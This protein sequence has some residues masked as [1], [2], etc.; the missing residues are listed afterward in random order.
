MN[1]YAIRD[2]LIGHFMPPF[3]APNDY[4]AKAAIAQVVNSEG[5]HAITKTPHHFEV[6]RIAYIENNEE[7]K[8]GKEFLADA[9]SLI[10]AGVRADTDR[11]PRTG[12]GPI[13]SGES[14]S[15]PGG[16]RGDPATQGAAPRSPPTTT[17][18][19]SALRGKRP[20]GIPR[21]PGGRRLTKQ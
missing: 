15:Q 4:E 14:R 13:E 5:D 9:S 17:R 19:P 21:H 18:I 12:Q 7:V 8:P 3:F 1:V 10:R 2:R 16:D 20:Q 11:K 6:W